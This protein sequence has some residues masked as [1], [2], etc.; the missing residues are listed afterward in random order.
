MSFYDREE[1]EY[2]RKRRETQTL[3]ALLQGSQGSSFQPDMEFSQ[4][5]P[6]PPEPGGSDDFDVGGAVTNFGI[7][8]LAAFLDIATNKG[9]G[10]GPILAAQGVQANQRALGRVDQ[11]RDKMQADQ[12]QQRF[13]GDAESRRLR[14]EALRVELEREKRLSQPKPRDASEEALRAAQTNNLEAEAYQKWTQDPGAM[15]PYQQESIR[16]QEER[17][18]KGSRG[19]GGGVVAPAELPE[20]MPAGLTKAQQGQ[21]ILARDK[22]Q[23]AM[24][25]EGEASVPGLEVTDE[26]AAQR[27][28]GDKVSRR[29][30][31]DGAASFQSAQAAL[32]RMQELRAKEGTM[33]FGEESKEYETLR[34]TVMSGIGK[35]ADAGVLQPS[36][37]ARFEKQ[38]PSAGLQWSDFSRLIGH[39]QTLEALGGTKKAMADTANTQ[40]GVRGFGLADGDGPVKMRSAS[41]NVGMV[42]PDKVEAAIA[43]GWTKVN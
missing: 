16:L 37:I 2:E 3:G 15:T 4:G 9:K 32:K 12:Y 35:A 25:A 22:E 29:K 7:P 24:G 17:L 34:N 5:G 33:I 28:L 39:D 8:L 36:D 1:D 10:L 23:R 30:L 43:A 11:A 13:E 20:G 31:E 26:P 38:V 19:G 14:E 18:K 27:T 6:L 21:W 40:L 42:P 41:G